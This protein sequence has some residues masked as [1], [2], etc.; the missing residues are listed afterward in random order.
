MSISSQI[1]ALTTDRN[2]IRVALVEQGVPEATDHGFDDFAEDIRGIVSGSGSAITITETPEAK[3]GTILEITA[4]DLSG[5]TVTAA[6]LLSGHTAH[7]AMGNP[8]T[9]TLTTGIT[10]TGTINITTNGTHDVTTY[11]SANIQVPTNS[12]PSLQSK[13]ASPTENVQVITADTG[14]DGLNQV[15]VEAISS[16]YVGS[17]ITHRSVTDLSASGGSVTVPAGYYSEQVSKSVASGSVTAPASISATSSTISAGTNTITLTKLVSITP[18]VT[19]GYVSSGT[20]RDSSVSLTANVTTKGAAT[21]TPTKSVQTIASGTYLTGTQTIA[22]IPNNYIDTTDA[23]AS[24]SDILSGETAYINGS[25]VT[26]TLTIQH[27]YTGS[28]VPSA[29]TGVNGDIYLQS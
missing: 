2:D 8:I 27:Y 3:G 25:L 21:I 7:D 11:A 23:T 10:P 12:D 6:R 26:G 15:T 17:D 16:T 1:T 28:S 13:T 19:A 20:A 4:V 22:A 9:G 29:S 18:S 5:D 14:Y 24:A